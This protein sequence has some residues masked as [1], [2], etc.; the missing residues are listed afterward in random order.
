MMTHNNI[1]IF[2]KVPFAGLVKTRLTRDSKITDI[3][4]SLIAEAMLKDT[5]LLT[6]DTTADLIE[7]GYTPENLCSKLRNIIDTTFK[8]E[9]LNKSISFILQHGLNFDEKF[10]SVVE[11]SFNNGAENLIILGADL[12]YLSPQIINS[13]FDLLNEREESDLIVVGP[14]NGGG[15]YLVGIS[16]SFNPKW[17]TKYQLFTGGVEIFQ[18]TSF[19]CKNNFKLK[20][21]PPYGDIDVEEDLVSLMSYIIALES[22]TES[23]GFIYPKYTAKILKDLGLYIKEIEGETRNRRIAKK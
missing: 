9:N 1:I 13:A 22:S 19:C 12:P 18:F 7:I 17:F 20:L 15:I 16:N 3:D 6:C 21:L 11:Q 5:L 4:A 8:T 2:T 23:K 14:S 10:A